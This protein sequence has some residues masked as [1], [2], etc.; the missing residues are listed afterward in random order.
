MPVWDNTLYLNN[1]KEI[2]AT[3]TKEKTS[4]ISSF[5]KSRLISTCLETLTHTE[6]SIDIKIFDSFNAFI[7]TQYL[8]SV[9]NK[10]SISIRIYN[11]C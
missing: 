9:S 10:L 5:P 7:D 3:L 1:I 4:G 2:K 8:I 11:W 6:V